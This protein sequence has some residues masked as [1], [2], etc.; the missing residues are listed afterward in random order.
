VIDD[1]AVLVSLAGGTPHDLLLPSHEVG[2]Q[3]VALI[4]GAT[5]EDCGAPVGVD[6]CTCRDLGAAR[7]QVGLRNVLWI[8]FHLQ[9]SP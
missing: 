6:N 7:L 9:G 8:R 3:V 4:A 2:I 1:E 5:G